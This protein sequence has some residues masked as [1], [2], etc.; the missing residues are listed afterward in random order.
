MF[1]KTSARQTGLPN[2]RPYTCPI[3]SLLGISIYAK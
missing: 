2:I 1:K 3:Y